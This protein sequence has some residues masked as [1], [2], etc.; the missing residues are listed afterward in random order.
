[1]KPEHDHL[2]M[3]KVWNWPGNASTVARVRAP[4]SEAGRGQAGPETFEG[5]KG[6]FASSE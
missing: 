6:L 2:V 4:G 1:M 5:R 3:M